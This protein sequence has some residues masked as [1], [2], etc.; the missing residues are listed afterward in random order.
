METLIGPHKAL[1]KLHYFICTHEIDRIIQSKVNSFFSINELHEMNS[2]KYEHVHVFDV[3]YP[4][5]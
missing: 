3:Y 1:F 2:L 5:Y 4:F